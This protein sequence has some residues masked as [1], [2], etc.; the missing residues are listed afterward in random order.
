VGFPV[1]CISRDVGAGGE[2]IGRVVADELG[3]RYVDEEI[4]RSAADRSGVDLATLSGAEERQSAVRRLLTAILENPPHVPEVYAAAPEVYTDPTPSERSRELIREAV[5]QAAHEGDV[6]IV[7]HAASHV[8]AGRPDVLRVL[9]TGSPEVRAERLASQAGLSKTKADATLREAEAG[10]ADYL[11]RFHQ[12]KE[13]LP[14]HYDLVVNTDALG[15]DAAAR[16][17]LATALGR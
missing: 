2:E 8:L 11:R 12:V 4:V 9:V 14:T 15:V 5:R 13:E 7:A 16:T 1:V 17:V 6:V 10:R 3:F